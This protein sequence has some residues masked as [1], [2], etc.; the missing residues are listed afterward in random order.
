MK[1]KSVGWA[2]IVAYGKW[3]N[4]DLLGTALDSGGKGLPPSN[5]SCTASVSPLEGAN[6]F[7]P[8]SQVC[9]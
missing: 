3:F 9:S 4:T 1:F 6:P 7:A 8:R 2:N 5:V